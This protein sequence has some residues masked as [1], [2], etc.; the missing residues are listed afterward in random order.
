MMLVACLDFFYLIFDN[1]SF[2]DNRG[3]L[4]RPKRFIFTLI[5]AIVII[6]GISGIACSAVALGVIYSDQ[7]QPAPNSG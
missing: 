5:A 7:P 4:G 1:I 3:R 6:L 2:A